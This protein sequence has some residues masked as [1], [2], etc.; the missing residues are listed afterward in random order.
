[1]SKP[2]KEQYATTPLFGSNAAAVEA[3]YEQFLAEPDSVPREWR[4][5]FSSLTNGGGDV[6]HGPIRAEQ[7][8]AGASSRAGHRSRQ[9][10]RSRPPCHA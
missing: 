3:L 10:P 7:P 6:A 1:M 8:G 2:L 4:R 9:P 5:Y